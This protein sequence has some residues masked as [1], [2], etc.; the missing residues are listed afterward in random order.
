MTT[1]TERERWAEIRAKAA[2]DRDLLLDVSG[3]PVLDAVARV[4]T[5]FGAEA[6]PARELICQAFAAGFTFPQIGEALGTPDKRSVRK[7]RDRH[8]HA[9]KRKLKRES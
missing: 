2:R 3:E 5:I 7:L 6:G 1:P 9:K 4:G 8:D